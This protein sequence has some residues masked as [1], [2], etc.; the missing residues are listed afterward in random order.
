MTQSELKQLERAEELFDDGKLDEALKLLANLNKFKGLDYQQK[1]YYQFLKGII[2]IYQNR[3][4]EVNELGNQMFN[5]SQKLGKNVQAFDG[6]CLV[7]IGFAL[8]DQFDEA[9]KYIEQ[10]ESLIQLFPKISR[11]ELIRRK[12]RINVLKAWIYYSQG[13]IELAEECLEIS[14]SF[15]TEIGITFEIVW[16]NL[17]NGLILLH[18]K[19]RVDLALENTKNV[20]SMVEKIKFK[21]FWIA[22][23]HVYFGVIYSV[24]GEFEISLEHSKKSLILFKKLNNKKYIAGLLNNIGIIHADK[25]EY[26]TALEYLEESL[27][28]LEDLSTEVESCLDNLIFVSLEMED[29]TRAQKYFTRLET[30]YN[31]KKDRH[32]TLLY[33]YNR[34]IMLK[35][36]SRIRDKAKAEKLMK[37]VVESET[38]S[39]DIT[40]SAL[41]HI[42]DLLLSEFS[43]NKNVEVLDE[44]N[45]Y[46]ARLRTIAENSHSYLIF[47]E[48]FILQ[49]RLA[50]LNLD[51]KAAR[52]F[53]TQAQKIAESYG[54]K[55]LAMKIS[56]EHDE[57]LKQL[58][59]W[60]SLKESEASL[61]ERWKFARLN[62]QMEHMLKK[63][64]IDI[65]ELS[66]EDPVLLLIISEGGVP[67]FSKSFIEDKA[68]ED[69]LFGG[70]FTAI[71]SFINEKFAEGL[72]RAS[73]G[74]HTLLMNSVSPFL[75]C[76][77]YKGQSYSAQQRL[78]YFIEKVQNQEQIWQT[79][80][81][82][83][84]LNKEVQLEDIPSLEP[85]IKEIFIEQVIP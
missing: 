70:F 69:H 20:L 34:A 8:G 16:A 52:R 19:R 33:N 35:R 15:Q 64:V 50:L 9:S 48:T 25:G 60:E 23:I 12:L 82:Y 54:I 80:V 10:T 29:T 24:I 65:P 26:H 75:L 53:L 59:I 36:S 31:E 38:F 21:H 78:K 22:M 32:T 71:N 57:L 72:D 63:S 45:Q 1:G 79:F 58:K 61:S 43:I 17:L 2:L 3:F 46:L 84:Q 67:F 27:K 30:L 28:L 14:S 11:E 7:I 66:D 56:H 74:E 62:E 40:I 68:F 81:N 5:E 41:I 4:E 85:L 18:V 55:R 37:K 47:C 73:F 49:A 76:Y 6:L 83:Y 77:V 39:I 42:C 51:I 13:E 44:I